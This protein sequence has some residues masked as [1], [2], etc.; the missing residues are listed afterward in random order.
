MSITIVANVARMFAE[1]EACYVSGSRSE[2]GDAAARITW[3]NAI[4]VGSRASSWLESDK[5]EAVEGMRSWAR[6]TGAWEEEE[7]SAWSDEEALALFAQNVASEIRTH[8]DADND[9]EEGFKAYEKTDWDS[10]PEYPTGHYYMSEV[11]DVHVSY[12]TGS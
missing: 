6:S 2:L 10:A 4:Q 11:L 5:A 8:L 12:Y 1:T 9:I 7:I 3:T